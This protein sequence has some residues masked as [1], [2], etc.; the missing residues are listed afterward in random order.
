MTC[1][2]FGLLAAFALLAGQLVNLQVVRHEEF[3]GRAANNTVRTIARDPMRGQILDIRGNPLATSIPA[4]LICADPSL[5]I[6]PNPSLSRNC[7]AAVARALAP[8]L[9][10]NEDY[11][12]ER[13]APRLVA[14]G[15]KTNISQYAALKH[16]VS[17][18]TWDR[19]KQTMAALSFGVDESKLARSDR[20]FLRSLRAK[21]IFATDEQKRVYPGLTLAAHVIGYV[22]GEGEEQAGMNGIE[23]EYNSKLSGIRGWRHTELDQRH[24]ELVAYRDEDIEPRD[25]LNVVLTLDAGLQNIMESELAAGMG[26]LSPI[27]ISSV[28]VRPR[29][30]EILALANYPT[31]DPNRPGA[32]P[33]EALRNR[34]IA[35]NHEP[36]STFKIVVVSGAL[37]ERLVSLN[38]IFY[39]EQGHFAYA[40]AI[41][42]DHESFGDLSVQS[43]ITKSSNIGAAK[44]GLRLGQTALHQYIRDFGFGSRTGIFLPGEVY[45]SVPPVKSW[46]KISIARIP[47]GQGIEVTPLQMVMALCAIANKGLLMQPMI[48]DRLVDPDGRV[49]VKYNPQPVRQVAGPATMSQMVAALKTVVSKDGTAPK[50]RLEHYTVAGKTGTAEKVENGH[51]VSDK[52][53]SSFIGFFPADNPELCIAVFIDEPPKGDHYGGAA[54]G[55]IFK[56]MAERAANYLNLKPDIDTT[57]PAGQTLAAAAGLPPGARPVKNN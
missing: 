15:G 29:T 18:E 42:H 8:L 16:Q 54:A 1:L 32:F 36:G 33:P 37:N 48:V 47:M 12:L 19:I 21:A 5:M 25:G 9:Q 4:K 26:Q 10:T 24:R 55:P 57:A 20:S 13:L 11:L 45:G 53:F 17:L 14:S 41:L 38:D 22:S 34:V 49:V 23:L 56:A 31:F 2:A 39:C 43:I 35:D 46:S 28:M 7:R 27:S 52:Y 3:L 6:C 44:I 51:Y 50:A 40:G 30:G